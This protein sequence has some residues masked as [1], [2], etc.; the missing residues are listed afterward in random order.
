MQKIFRT[1]CKAFLNT[2]P[3][4]ACRRFNLLNTLARLYP[5]TL[6][7]TPH[8]L[9]DT[10][11]HNFITI[12][13]QKERFMIGRPSRISLYRNGISPRLTYLYNTYLANT[14]HFTADDL[15]VDC[16]ANVG[17]FTASIQRQFGVRAIC[18]EPEAIEAAA[19]KQNTDKHRTNVHER[20]L[21]KESIDVEFYSGNESGDSSVFLAHTTL[22]HKKVRASTLSDLISAD[23]LFKTAKKIKL[24]KIEAEGAE[25]EI[26]AGADQILPAVEYVTVDCGPERGPDKKTTLIDVMNALQQHGFSP[27]QF[28]HKRVVM[29]F[30]RQES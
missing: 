20:V 3:Q 7:V 15:I 21:W 18:I 6:S 23:P 24:L 9:S 25:P 1:Y 26:L 22:P 14:L 10:T 5:I 11:R 28:N 27:I 4:Q 8:P 17:E 19:C 13:D 29:L 16:G 30:K 12:T 2:S